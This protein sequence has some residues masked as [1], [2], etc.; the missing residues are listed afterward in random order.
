M[1]K[2]TQFKLTRRTALRHN[3]GKLSTLLM[4]KSIKKKDYTK[5]VEFMSTDHSTSSRN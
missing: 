5:S 3:L 2:V 1:K 4:L